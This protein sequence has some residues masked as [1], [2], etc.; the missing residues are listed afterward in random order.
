MVCNGTASEPS[1]MGCASYESDDCD[2]NGMGDDEQ[3]IAAGVAH[4]HRLD[5]DA[6]V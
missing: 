3:C 5:P 6:E 2:A 4:A 1:A